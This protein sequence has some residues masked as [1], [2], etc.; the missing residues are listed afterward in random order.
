MQHPPSTVECGLATLE[1]SQRCTFTSVT[2][3]TSQV[4]LVKLV[5]LI[6][7]SKVGIGIGDTGASIST[8]TPT[9]CDR[10]WKV[11]LTATGSMSN[12]RT[13]VFQ[14]K[15]ST[16]KGVQ[17]DAQIF[18]GSDELIFYKETRTH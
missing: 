11:K 12:A 2:S 18:A 10:I 15:V 5:K 3:L 14:L 16:Y 4:E 17:F 7:S 1:T 13:I 8:P 6:T 9:K